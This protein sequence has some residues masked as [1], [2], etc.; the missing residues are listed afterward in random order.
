MGIGDV[1][2]EV[3]DAVPNGVG[4]GRRIVGGS[5]DDR[6]EGTG[7]SD[8]IL[9]DPVPVDDQGGDDEVW[10]YGGDDLIR[11]FGGDNYVDGGPG[12]DELV[13]ADGDDVILG[14]PGDDEIQG[15][16]GTDILHGGRGDDE[17]RGGEGD[18]A[19]YGDAGDDRVIGSSGNDLVHGGMGADELEGREGVDSFAWSSAAE[20]RDVVLDY[21]YAID[22]FVVGDILRGYGGDLGTLTRHVR[23]VPTGDGAAC[24]LQVDPDGGGGVPWRDLAVV[25]GQPKLNATALHQVGDL[26]L[27]GQAAP[28]P[29]LALAYVASHDDLIDALGTDGAAGKRHYLAHGHEEGRTTNFDGLQYIAGYGDLILAFGPDAEAG[30]AHFIRPGQDEGRDRDGFDEAQYLANY[31]DLQA[32]FGADHDAATRHFI[33]NGF[34]EGRTD[35]P[36]GAADFIL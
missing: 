18:D 16:R 24:L 21:E 15:G 36:T 3:G 35:E 8:E 20:G 17:V 23:F 14:G 30:A 31:A 12:D 1:L 28:A 27:E 9:A 25:A 7:S 13:T 10:G 34:A 33:T 6:I 26:V 2:D 22:R 29:F 19:I 4:A 11:A 32:A 5:G